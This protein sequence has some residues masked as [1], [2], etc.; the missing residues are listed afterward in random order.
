M[1]AARWALNVLASSWSYDMIGE[2][3]LERLRASGTRI[4][5]AIWHGNLLPAIWRHRGEPTT[6]LVSGHRD[7]GILAAT[8]SPWGYRVVRGSSTRGAVGGLMGLL[9][10]LEDGDNVALTPDGPRGPPRIAKPG[11]IAA[12]QRTGAVIVPVGT[13]ASSGWH[14]GSWDQ[15][16][17]PRPFARVRLVYETPLSVR[18]GVDGMRNGLAELQTRLELATRKAE[19][20]A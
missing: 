9:Q 11:V 6:L 2:S 18:Q 20:F 7:G 16:L 13:G 3:H 15:F 14:A 17:V 4:V 5:Y 12:A 8:V 1:I 10:A 19:C